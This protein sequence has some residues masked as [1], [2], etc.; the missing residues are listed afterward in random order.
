MIYDL[1]QERVNKHYIRKKAKKTIKYKKIITLKITSDDYD[2]F[3]LI[4][5]KIRNFLL[6]HNN[7]YL[8]HTSDRTDLINCLVAYLSYI[9]DLTHASNLSYTNNKGEVSVGSL[10]RNICAKHSYSYNDKN[11]YIEYLNLNFPNELSVVIKE[12]KKYNI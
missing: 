10:W 4:K 3:I 8:V 7:K 1:S 11:S 9:N 5:T 12:I 2:H 6:G